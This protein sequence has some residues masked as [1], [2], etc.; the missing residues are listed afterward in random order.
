MSNPSPHL[1]LRAPTPTQLS[2]SFCDATPRD[3]KRWIAG[4]PKANLGET[5]RLL[6]QGLGELNL[7]L[8]PSE[9]RL[10]LLELLRPEVYYVCKHLERHFL[11]QSIVLDERPRKVANLCQALQNHL[12][13][14][15]KQIAMRVASKGGKDRS[16]LLTTSIQRALHCLNGPL[17]RASQL[18]CPVPESLWF[19][20]HQLYQLALAHQV[21]TTPVFDEQASQALPLSV[22][23][24]YIVA[25][26]LGCARS[27]QLRQNNI[28]RL[29]EVLEPWSS[30]VK[31]Q[32][33]EQASSLFAVSP[34]SDAPP[35]YT[36]LFA[37]EQL[38]SLIGIDTLPLVEAIKDYLDLPAD[39][40]SQSRLQVPAGLS[41]DVLQHLSAAWGEAAERTFQRTPGQGTVTLCVG[42]S[43]LHF[44]LGGQRSFSDILKIPAASK[45]AQFTV[46]LSNSA[47][48]DAWNNAFDAQRA[49]GSDTLL[50][51][52]EIQYHVSDADSSQAAFNSAEDFPTH[53]LQIINHSPGGYCLAWPKEVPAQLQ[54]GEMIGVQDPSSQGWSVAVVRWIRQVRS[55]GTQMGIELIAPHAQPCGLQ[56]LRGGEGHSQ[57]LRALLLPEISAIGVPATLLAPR[58]PFQEGH[59]VVINSNGEERRAVLSKRLASTGSFNQFEYRL[60][61]QPAAPKTDP[62]AGGLGVAEDD[63]GSLWKIL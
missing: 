49:G 16:V 1:L 2:L 26:L 7:L 23:R 39:L 12:A 31:L 14:G 53:G 46:Q 11:N 50:P 60:L 45:A 10:Q 27:N 5:A 56:L 61:E 18:Y 37:V 15:Y 38:P 6:Y 48:K 55:G 42:M 25:L 9:N 47:E 40:R 34:G 52:E 32:G 21:H 22:E 51:Y 36:S 3:L 20:V 8:T 35:R 63:F 33:A 62:S 17:V 19:E 13:I 57:Y 4:L 43:A 54:A 24:T 29:S 28:A 44:Y 30:Q 58:L 59:K 41:L